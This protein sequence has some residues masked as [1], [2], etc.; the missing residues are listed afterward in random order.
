MEDQ[1]AISQ[2]AASQRILILGPSGS[3]KTTLTRQL[4]R[5]LNIEALHL[6]ALF[7]QAG[8]KSTPQDAWRATVAQLLEHPSWIMDGTYESTLHVRI[9]A[10]DALIILER[11]RW[12][13]LWQVVKRKL[14]IDDQRRPDAPPGQP[15]D[16]PYLRYIWR[17][18]Y[19]TQPQMNDL[20][21]QHGREKLQIVLRSTTETAALVERLEH[22][23][24]LSGGPNPLS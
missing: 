3:G 17:Y 21:Q 9:P 20:I 23:V 16:W 13:C 7:W 1:D 15:I 22:A 5:I 10:A 24:R 18:P 19:V 2:L 4:S 11:N 14:T 8:W 6:D 12:L